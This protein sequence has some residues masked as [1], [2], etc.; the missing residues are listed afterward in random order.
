MSK[1]PQLRA[2][3]SFG[4]RGRE[5]RQALENPGDID[6]VLASQWPPR[7]RDELSRFS[8]TLRLAVIAPGNALPNYFATRVRRVIQALQNRAARYGQTK[9]WPVLAPN[10]RKI[11][12]PI[13]D[14]ASTAFKQMV[15]GYDQKY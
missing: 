1:Q 15:D 3:R 5:R 12:F 13:N 8:R 2:L 10:G 7:S 9:T 14:Y 4:P 6:A 11:L